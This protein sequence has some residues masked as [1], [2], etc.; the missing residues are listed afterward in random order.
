MGTLDI[1]FASFKF[2]QLKY[3]IQGEAGFF[4]Y[5]FIPKNIY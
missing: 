3:L 4:F 1:N 2:D 5:N